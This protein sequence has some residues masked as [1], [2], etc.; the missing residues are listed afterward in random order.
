MIRNSVARGSAMLS[1][2]TMI[3][4]VFACVVGC[5]PQENVPSAANAGEAQPLFTDLPA[6]TPLAATHALTPDPEAIRAELTKA[7]QSYVDACVYTNV[8]E[9][10]QQPEVYMHTPI[11][12]TVSVNA[13]FLDDLKGTFFNHGEPSCV[14]EGT[15]RD[16]SL[17]EYLEMYS[18]AVLYGVCDEVIE[19]SETAT[20][21]QMQVE[22]VRGFNADP[23]Y[24]DTPLRAD[25]L[26]GIWMEDPEGRNPFYYTY[27]FAGNHLLLKSYL[28]GKL[29]TSFDGAY[30]ITKPGRIHHRY[31]IT[32]YDHNTGEKLG[33]WPGKLN[34]DITPFSKDILRVGNAF[35]FRVGAAL[36]EFPP[37]LTENSM[38][39]TLPIEPGAA[40]PM[41]PTPTA[42][43]EPPHAAPTPTVSPTASDKKRTYPTSMEEALAISDDVY[44]WITVSNISINEP[45]LHDRD[46]FYAEHDLFGNASRR[47]SV[48]LYYPQ[49]VK[50]NTLQGNSGIAADKPLLLDLHTLKEN[51]YSLQRR[52]N[53]IFKIDLFG[54]KEWELFALYQ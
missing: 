48:F 15:F 19:K 41:T 32:S 3:V 13:L 51:P 23:E 17:I 45:L 24:L 53:R 34:H 9:A 37:I 54:I 47:G 1:M 20:V 26:E 11:L 31:T 36:P 18:Y 29:S 2:F 46:F 35:Y 30:T 28:Y 42:S 8:V 44:G 14:I 5:S 40:Q 4:I 7:R 50:N 12:L 25:Y 6:A 49:L 33:E 43:I 16:K 22:Y 10:I 38:H 52:E 39:D 21:V 27:T